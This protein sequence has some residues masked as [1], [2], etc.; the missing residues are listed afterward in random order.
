MENLIKRYLPYAVTILAIFLLVPLIFRAPA[1]SAYYSVALYFI[2]PGAAI[3][4]S[5][6]YC[7]K[8]G[9][10]FLFTLI[11]PIIYIPT[12]LI[13]YGGFNFA[14]IILLAVYLIASIFGL[15]LGDIALG[16]K[17]RQKEKK[18]QEEA[19]KVLL[20]EKRKA[21]AELERITE[22]SAQAKND[23]GSYGGDDDF[24]YSNYASNTDKAPTHSTEDEIDAILNEYGTDKR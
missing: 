13:Y 15:F 23:S 9:M 6:L 1:L 20:E 22:E 24:D 11:A 17:R 19:E 21:D 16:D 12:M 18:E 8:H 3:I 4:S 10:D 14:N 7:S 5:A 2:F